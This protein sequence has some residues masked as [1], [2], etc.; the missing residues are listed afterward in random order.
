M[1][2]AFRSLRGVF[3]PLA[4]VAGAACFDPS[5]GPGDFSDAAVIVINASPAPVDVLVDGELVYPDLPASLF[6]YRIPI[7]SGAR[8]ITLRTEAGAAVNSAMTVP[9]WTTVMIA[10]RTSVGSATLETQVLSDT[11]A[12]AVVGKGKLRV[13][14]LAPDAPR[15][16][17]WR[18]QPDFGDPVRVMTP[19]EFPDVS[20]YIL[21]DPGM[22]RVWATPLSGVGADT[23]LADTGPIEV[24]GSSLV[25]VA[26]VDSAGVLRFRVLE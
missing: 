7:R 8:V 9:Q 11:N 3:A 24:P 4:L 26:L 22:W 25:T 14:H 21:S 15:L 19:F 17:I 1:M 18:T 23:V 20:P 13:A 2:S 5:L 6:T 10:G 16:D 12:I